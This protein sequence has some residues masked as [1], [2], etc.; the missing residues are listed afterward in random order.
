MAVSSWEQRSD[1]V[2]LYGINVLDCRVLRT[3]LPPYIKS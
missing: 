1:F 3:L 2:T